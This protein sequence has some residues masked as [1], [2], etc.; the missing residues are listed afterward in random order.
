MKNERGPAME[1]TERAPLRTGALTLLLTVTALCLAVLAVL[2]LVT[3]RAD[4]VLARRGA[5]QLTRTAAADNAGQ[6]WL[7]AL[8]AAL[9]ADP[10]RE[11]GLPGDARR[12]GSTIRADLDCGEAG[13]LHAAVALEDGGW[14]VTRWQL[15]R[16]WQPEERLDVWE[17]PGE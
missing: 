10:A 6:Q 1:R 17:G 7:A 9:L 3:A 2:A 4:L 15:E 5:A 13:V 11:Q 8:D 14:R 16:P 12:E